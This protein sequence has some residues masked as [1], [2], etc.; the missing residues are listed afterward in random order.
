MLSILCFRK[1]CTRVMRQR[2]ITHPVTRRLAERLWM[3]EPRSHPPSDCN[4]KAF[5]TTSCGRHFP[6]PHPCAGDSPN[7]DSRYID[8]LD[9]Y[10]L[11]GSQEPFTD[12][13]VKLDQ[14][15]ALTKQRCNASIANY[16]SRTAAES[17]GATTCHVSSTCL[18][19]S[20][21]ME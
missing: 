20:D 13:V 21:D 2:L 3:A 11:I 18:S 17:C 1:R 16:H 9:R 4:R 19:N 7:L 10:V 12:P 5:H 14:V 15:I 6:R 8:L